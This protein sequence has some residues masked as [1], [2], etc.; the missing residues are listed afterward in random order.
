M[1]SARRIG[2]TARRFTTVRFVDT[3][4]LL[5]GVSTDPAEEAKSTLARELLSE[6]DLAVSV[7]VLQEFYVQS[8]R[9]SRPDALT[10]EQATKLVESFLRFPVA[11]LSASLML[12]ALATHQRWQ[13]S[14]WDAAIVEAARSLGCGVLLSEDL[15]HGQ[16]Y[17]GVLVENPF[18][19]T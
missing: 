8:T 14:Y 9:P 12:A 13:I 16:D 3:N 6:R 10:H 7:Q 2:L 11:E 19:N 4:V 17:A 18:R 1:R 5:Y 15:S